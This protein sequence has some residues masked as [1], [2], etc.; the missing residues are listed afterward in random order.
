MTAVFSSGTIDGA[1][2][3]KRDDYTPHF[4]VAS[5]SPTADIELTALR[6]LY[7]CHSDVVASEVCRSGPASVA[8]TSASSPT[9]KSIP[10][11]HRTTRRSW[12]EL[13]KAYCLPLDW[14]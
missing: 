12:S 14:N 4:C 9:K 2:V 8:T 10:T 13:S 3:T 5:R 1:T 7:E 11:M 6:T